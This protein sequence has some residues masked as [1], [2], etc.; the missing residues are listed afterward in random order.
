M[1]TTQKITNGVRCD[2]RMFKLCFPKKRRC[3]SPVKNTDLVV[4]PEVTGRPTKPFSQQPTKE[5]NPLALSL[6]AT[7]DNNSVGAI[8]DCT[9]QNT[10]LLNEL[11]TGMFK[12]KVVDVYD[13]DTVR[14]AC[15]MMGDGNKFVQLHIR[16]LGYDS[17]ELRPPKSQP[18]RDNEKKLALAAR[19]RLR[20]IVMGKIVSINIERKGDKYGRRVGTVWTTA[21]HDDIHALKFEDSVNALM[22]REGH[23]DPYDGGKKERSWDKNK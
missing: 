9:A 2:T 1:M 4:V 6:A 13:G 15:P 5:K 20:D 8:E 14:V 10:P 11:F 22:M 19:D 23:G 12:T 16:M 18:G 3:K 7:K 21:T 17:P